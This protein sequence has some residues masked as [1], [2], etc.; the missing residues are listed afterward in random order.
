M[1]KISNHVTLPENEIEIS[2]VRAS[3]PGGQNVNKVASAVHLR[4]D[5]TASSLP[6]FYKSRL[7]KLHDRRITRDGVII[8]K[9]QRYRSLEKN[10]E[11]ALHRLRELIKK[12][13]TS[14]RQRIPTRPP[15][16][17][18]SRR[19]DEKTRRSKLKARRGRVKRGDD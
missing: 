15:K 1:L 12:A 4:F 14:Y 2:A 9:A 18:D 11:D 5:I 16:S 13:T 19:L 7:L 17:A 10:R 8:I 3:G 6:D